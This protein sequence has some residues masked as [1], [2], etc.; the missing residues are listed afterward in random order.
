MGKE[1]LMDEGCVRVETCMGVK[2]NGHVCMGTDGR[3]DG[4]EGGKL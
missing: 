3:G 2:M 1:W 4:I